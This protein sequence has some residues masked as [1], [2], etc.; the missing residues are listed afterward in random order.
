MPARS[1]EVGLRSCNGPQ[2]CKWLSVHHEMFMKGWMEHVMSF[3]RSGPVLMA[4][5]FPQSR[6]CS[7]Q[8][9]GGP[10]RGFPCSGAGGC[11]PASQRLWLIQFSGPIV[12]P[13]QGC[14]QLD[15]TARC[16][17]P[18]TSITSFLQPDRSSTIL[19]YLADTQW[20][21]TLFFFLR[22]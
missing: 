13:T 4:R 14:G 16:S 7:Y 10:H 17:T 6:F 15:M 2:L 1:T 11:Q 18:Y 8:S 5:S 3:V 19:I 9:D 22:K 21:L 12:D 20:I